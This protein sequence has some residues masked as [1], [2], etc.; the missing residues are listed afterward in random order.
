MSSLPQYLFETID[1]EGT[2]VV[3]RRVTW[4]AKAGNDTLG[5]H[6]EVRDYRKDVKDAIA[7]PDLVFQSTRD[8]RS[9]VCYR[10]R[11]GRGN[12]AGKHLVV[13]VKYVQ[14]ASSQRGYVSTIYL[15]RG[16]YAQGAPLWPKTQNARR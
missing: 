13:V 11:V 12:F 3:L 4:Q 15:S 10:L 14:Q 1:Y 7:S 9:R 2:P 16:V 5:I 6:P 8:A